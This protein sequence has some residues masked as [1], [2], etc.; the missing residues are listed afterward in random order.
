MQCHQDLPRILIYHWQSE[1]GE[2]TYKSRKVWSLYFYWTE[3]EFS[4]VVWSIY[5][6]KRNLIKL[7]S[8]SNIHQ[9]CLLQK[10]TTMSICHFTSII[11]F[12]VLP[13]VKSCWTNFETPD[14]TLKPP[15][16][17]IQF[18]WHRP[19][20]WP[21][22]SLVTWGTLKIRIWL[23]RQRKFDPTLETNKQ[24]FSADLF[25]YMAF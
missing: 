16:N 8:R 9:R 23:V 17:N 14:Q 10:Y 22:V 12:S 11:L 13:W 6:S 2:K 18:S 21:R 20:Q 5:L 4:F 1:I 15:R 25:L 19:F 24:T 7:Q 3:I